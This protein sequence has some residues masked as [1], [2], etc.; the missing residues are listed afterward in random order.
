MP[1]SAADM[2]ALVDDVDAYHRFL[3]W[4]RSSKVLAR[5]GDE[6]QATIELA[7]GPINR[8]F[9]TLNRLQTDKMIE[10]RLIEGPFRR[11]EGFW[12]FDSLE[13]GACKVSLDLE[14]EFSNKLVEAAIGPV[15]Q[16]IAA[17]LVDAFVKRAGEIYG[18]RGQD[19]G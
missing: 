17:S 6:V 18:K 8:S 9:T 1:Y 13:A 19:K 5:N 12:R 14:F 2:F 11:L 4:C 16:Q 15:F 10:V 7:K 3:P